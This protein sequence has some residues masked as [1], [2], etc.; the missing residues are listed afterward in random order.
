VLPASEQRILDRLTPEDLVLDVGAGASP[1]VRADWV[2]DLVA[3]EDRG[4][5]GYDDARRA[6]ERFTAAT[7]VRQDMCARESWPFAD[8]QFDFAVCSHV[9]EDVRD[10]VWVCQ[11]LTRVAKAGYIEVPSRLE[12][13]AWGAQ[14]PWVG[15]GHHHWLIDVAPASI[16][17]VFK[18]H[19]LH[20]HPDEHFA[21]G[22]A[23]TLTPEQRVQ[24]LWWE[25]PFEARE[26]IFTDPLALVDYLSGFV[27]ANAPPPQRRRG[28][29]RR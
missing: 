25:G 27:A 11:E 20:G 16:E 5:Y 22:F 4:L 15:W 8:G 21:A 24:Q 12:E 2:L 6:A 7:W 26:R 10:P 17:F 18:H 13:Q 23:Q 29:L 3:Y 14:G 9:L 19:V 1:F 28:L